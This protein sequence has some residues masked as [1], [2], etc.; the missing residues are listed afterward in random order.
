MGQDSVRLFA[1]VGTA[2]ALNGGITNTS[3]VPGVVLNYKW[4][5]KIRQIDCKSNDPIVGKVFW[6]SLH[7]HKMIARFAFLQFY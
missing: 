2:F 6:F 3:T 7:L 5:I 1:M 4:N